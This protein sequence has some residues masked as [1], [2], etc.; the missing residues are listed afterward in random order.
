MS[1][2]L[3]PLVWLTSFVAVVDHGTFTSAAQALHR[4]QP[5]VSS[6]VA[7]LERH[8]AVPLLERG[9]RGV[10]LTEAGTVFLPQARAVLHQLRVGV[11]AVS[12]LSDTLHGRIRIGSYP[13]A[14]AVILAPL[15]RR[16]Q[17]MYP[18]VSVELSEGE[19]GRLEEAIAAQEI[20]FALR[21][22]DVPQR[23]HD[24]PSASLF[25][26]RILL[27]VR[28]DHPL[29]R[30][31]EVDPRLL[32]TETVIVSGDSIT[33]WQDYRDRLD[34]VGVDPIRMITVVQPTTV[35]ALVR[36]GLGVG[37]LGALASKVTVQGRETLAVNLPG[38][39]WQREIRLYRNAS[40]ATTPAESAFVELLRTDGPSLAAGRT[41]W[42]SVSPEG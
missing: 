23:H 7:S 2:E 36:E 18:G 30:S 38:P 32:E 21:T 39:L 14:M 1:A 13:G 3:P 8:L 35:V 24:V 5:R 34:Q 20:D 15:V 27:V 10:E 41:L 19:P 31:S 28:H 17:T 12:A 42:P 40:V 16:Y 37:L 4:S 33:G 6:H 11:D 9:S 22:A 29:A 25:H 26:E